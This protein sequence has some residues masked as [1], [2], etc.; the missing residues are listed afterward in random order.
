MIELYKMHVQAM[1][2]KVYLKRMVDLEDRV[3]PL[4]EMQLQKLDFHKN[5]EYVKEVV[6][7]YIEHN[8]AYRAY[9]RL[10]E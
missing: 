3:I 9:V 4:E 1:E 8:Q 5:P 7:K 10:T 6:A 2:R